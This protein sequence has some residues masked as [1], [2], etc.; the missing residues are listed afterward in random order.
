ME[1]LSKYKLDKFWI[2]II[3]GI[4]GAIVGF[5]I[6]GFFWAMANE[7]TFSYFFNDV[8]LGTRFF[9]DKIV[10]VSILLDVLLFFIFMRLNWLNMCKGIL[11]VV[12]LAVPV[13]IYFY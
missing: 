12:I 9:T 2:G 3:V 7:V 8:F 6:F 4:V 11:G 1:L 10:T 13:A 5:L